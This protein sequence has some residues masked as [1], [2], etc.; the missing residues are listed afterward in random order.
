MSAFQSFSV[1]NVNFLI[2]ITFGCYLLVFNFQEASFNLNTY[3]KPFVFGKESIFYLIR[4]QAKFF[5][6]TEVRSSVDLSAHFISFK[7]T[8][9]F[10][11]KIN[12][13]GKCSRFYNRS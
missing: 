5:T 13:D 10:D 12:S 3:S 11:N 8:I 1:F 7:S 4:A 6:L 2:L 9:S